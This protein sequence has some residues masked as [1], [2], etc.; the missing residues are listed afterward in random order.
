M[1]IISVAIAWGGCAYSARFWG[2]IL[3]GDVEIFSQTE[4]LDLAP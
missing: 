4:G 1:I 3:H 2:K